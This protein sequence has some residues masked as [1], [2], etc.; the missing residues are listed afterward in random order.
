MEF[1]R[2]LVVH[3]YHL[4]PAGV[5]R[6]I[7]TALPALIARGQP[8]L[9]RVVILTGEA[10][11]DGWEERL[12]AACPIALEFVVV[13]EINYTADFR[14]SRKNQL[15]LQKIIGPNA[16]VWSHNLSVGRHFGMLVDL[17]AACAEIGA[18]LLLHH[19]DWWFDNRWERVNKTDFTRLARLTFPR[20]ANVRHAVLTRREHRPLAPFLP[21]VWLPNPVAIEPRISRPASPWFMPCRVLRRKNILEALLLRN[22]IS[23]RSP[24][25][26]MG[27]ASSPVEHAYHARLHSLDKIEFGSGYQADGPIAVTSLLEGFGLP[28]IETAA[29]QR[30]FIGRY[31]RNASPDIEHAGCELPLRYR[32]VRV[33]REWLDHTAEKKRQQELWNQWHE[34]LPTTAQRFV[35]Q[36]RLPRNHLAFSRLTLTGQLEVLAQKPKGRDALACNP[37]LAEAITTGQVPTTNL[38]NSAKTFFSPGTYAERFWRAVNRRIGH[39]RS[40]AFEAL[41]RQKMASD[42]LY[43]LL[44]AEST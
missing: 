5:R 7:E 12:R 4:R 10:S 18:Q 38:N 27:Q 39:G 35:R 21:T 6:V 26:V 25:R 28:F 16:L 17:P 8:T 1:P 43:P 33:D 30:P 3:H 22:W 41:L 44:M 2:T 36:P 34:A 24:L 19:H 13:P 14:S 11:P 15:R 37:E 9:R 29:A 42:N 23:P 32:E 20:G 40:G 31:L